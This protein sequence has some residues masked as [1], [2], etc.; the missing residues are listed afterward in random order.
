VVV[1]AELPGVKKEDL[2]VTLTEDTISI[3]GE[4]KKEEK[5]EKKNYYHW[6]SAYGS[7][8]GTF[9]PGA[10][11]QTEKESRSLKMVF[12]KYGYQRLKKR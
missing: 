12:W 10:E 3:A 8:V 4:K 9:S 2:D 1:N 6:E 11:V 5:V 7:F